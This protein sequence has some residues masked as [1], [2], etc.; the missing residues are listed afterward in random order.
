MSGGG[1][2]YEPIDL[3]TID[4]GDIKRFVYKDPLM[5]KQPRSRVAMA[6]DLKEQLDMIPRYNLYSFNCET[7][8]HKVSI[9]TDNLSIQANDSWALYLTPKR[10]LYAD[11]WS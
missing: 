10:L 7:F 3:R 2:K 5:P 6:L 9:N 8:V 1:L 11:S 4:T